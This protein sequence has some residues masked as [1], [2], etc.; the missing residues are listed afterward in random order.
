MQSASGPSIALWLQHHPFPRYVATGGVCF[1]IDLLALGVLHGVLGVGLVVATIV[2]YGVAFFVNF[3]LS[4]R[5]T[6]RT[7]SP[8]NARRQASRF[9]IVVLCNL[10]ATVVIVA[11]LAGAGMNYLLAKVISGMVIALVNFVVSRRW[12][13]I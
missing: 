2:A 1:G 7:A 12:V 10:V 11:G 5:W 3:T 9:T 8:T 4:R 6:F 13:F